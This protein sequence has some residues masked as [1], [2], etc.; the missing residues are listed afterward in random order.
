MGSQRPQSRP[1][2]RRLFSVS[3]F[4][5]PTKQKSKNE[6]IISLGSSRYWFDCRNWWYR[7]IWRRELIKCD[8]VCKS[9]QQSYFKRATKL[10]SMKRH[11]TN[12]AYLAMLCPQA[13]VSLEFSLVNKIL[14]R[15]LVLMAWDF[16]PIQSR[17]LQR[18]SRCNTNSSIIKLSTIKIELFFFICLH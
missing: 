4:H 10:M 13:T 17:F 11:S 12:S 5:K 14:F 9:F 7:V 3:K 1:N 8:T 2:F 16:L 18:C 15:T 6:F